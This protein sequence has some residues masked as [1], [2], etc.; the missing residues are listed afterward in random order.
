[1]NI[2]LI[3]EL[4]VTQLDMV[5]IEYTVLEL[6][7]FPVSRL[8]IILNEVMR[9]RGRSVT[10]SLIIVHYV[11]FN[12]ISYCNRFNTACKYNFSTKST[13]ILIIDY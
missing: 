6:I 10:L 13:F 1:M 11:F 3:N 5:L 12:L 8:Q 7:D 9:S 2:F 4:L